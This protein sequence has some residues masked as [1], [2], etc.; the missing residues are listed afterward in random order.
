VGIVAGMHLAGR[1]DLI[2]KFARI[3]AR[4]TM[5]GRHISYDKDGESEVPKQQ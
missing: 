3:F 2:A 1:T 5:E 4:T